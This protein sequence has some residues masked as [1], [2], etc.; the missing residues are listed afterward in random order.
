MCAGR[1]IEGSHPVPLAIKTPVHAASPKILLFARAAAAVRA[2]RQFR[3]IRQTSFGKSEGAAY[4][5]T[6]SPERNSPMRGQ[7][8]AFAADDGLT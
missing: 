8:T 2:A 4:S 7:N 3:D 5:Q 6:G 1:R